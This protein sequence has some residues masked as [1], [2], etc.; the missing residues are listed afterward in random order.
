M[1]AGRTL[2]ELAIELSRQRGAKKDMMVDTGALR[3]DLNAI[4]P[5]TLSKPDTAIAMLELPRECAQPLER[6]W[7]AV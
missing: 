6:L 4:P 7:P 3:M 1:K 2:Q 5:I